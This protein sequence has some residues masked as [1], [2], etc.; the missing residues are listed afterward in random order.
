MSDSI[1]MG[2]EFTA[3][4]A[5]RI[6]WAED[7][8]MTD[9]DGRLWKFRGE[10]WHLYT[11]N[12]TTSDFLTHNLSPYKIA[13]GGAETIEEENVC[14]PEDAPPTPP[15]PDSIPTGQV[16]M[17]IYYGRRC[18][19][20]KGEDGTWTAISLDTGNYYMATSD[21]EITRMCQLVEKLHP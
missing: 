13:S 14:S 4:E 17:G 15:N 8:I 5:A 12:G 16:W 19:M 3:K 7:T 10:S 1:T 11:R 18:V 20:V 9:R 2:Q 6:D 21:D